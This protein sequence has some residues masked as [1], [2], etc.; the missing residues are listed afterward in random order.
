MRQ[1][2]LFVARSAR[3]DNFRQDS[4]RPALSCTVGQEDRPMRMP[5]AALL[6]A[7]AAFATPASALQ[8]PPMEDALRA[9]PS[10]LCVLL[11]AGAGATAARLAEGGRRLVHVLV[12][13]EAKVAAA[14]RL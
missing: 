2:T 7:W 12:A 9:S 11:G 14:R 5:C 13:D 4:T 10:G 8:E 3:T 6:L 1:V